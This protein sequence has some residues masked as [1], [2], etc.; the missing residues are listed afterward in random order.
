LVL[1]AER[2]VDA[3]TSPLRLLGERKDLMAL[4]RAIIVINIG[5]KPRDSRRYSEIYNCVNF[6]TYRADQHCYKPGRL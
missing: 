6:Y 2:L 4:K 3:S 1:L 5:I